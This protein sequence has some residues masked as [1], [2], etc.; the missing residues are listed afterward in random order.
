MPSRYGLLLSALIV[1]GC[2]IERTAVDVLSVALTS[3]GG[4]YTTDDDPELIREALPFGLKTYE[5]LL[6]VSP[7]NKRLLLSA[8]QGF[9]AYAY[10]LQQDADRVD[11]ADLA[12]ARRIRARST[13]LYL[14]ARDYALRGLTVEHENFD[15]RIYTETQAVLGETEAADA[16]FLYWAGV[17]WA[18]ALGTDKSNAELIAALPL[19]GALVTRVLDL[20]ETYDSG[21]AYEFLITY[22]GARPG[23]SAADARAY[24]EKALAL[25]G[26]MRAGVY[27]ALAEAVTIAEQNVAEFRRLIRLALAVDPDAAPPE[28]RLVN[29]IAQRR[30]RWLETRVSDLFFDAE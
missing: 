25:S 5:G 16:P 12:Q 2:S 15:Q 20:D 18:G 22:E 23:G 29:V 7:E 11:A 30:A 13:N 14:R 19:A 27:V 3:G 26:G 17:A 1:G 6:D 21:A 9:A 8:A 10:L 4:V 28:A 24:Y